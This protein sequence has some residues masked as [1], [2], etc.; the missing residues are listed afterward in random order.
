MIT[1]GFSERSLF[2]RFIVLNDHR[3]EIGVHCSERSLFRKKKLL[4]R[5]FF[6]LKLSRPRL[7]P[8]I[9]IQHGSARF[10]MGGYFFI[11]PRPSQNWTVVNHCF[12][13]LFSTNS[14]LSDIVIR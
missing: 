8:H 5:R 10:H 4:F 6:A 12:T 11:T 3:S 2:R 14:L 7:L 9:L 1:A 13:P